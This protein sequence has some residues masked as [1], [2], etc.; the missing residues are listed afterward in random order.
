MGIVTVAVF[1]GGMIVIFGS[2]AISLYCNLINM[3]SLVLHQQKPDSSYK[4]DTRHGKPHGEIETT[5]KVMLPI[6]MG[7]SFL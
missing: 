4:Q 3:A 7:G 6:T 2:A 1:E 5:Y